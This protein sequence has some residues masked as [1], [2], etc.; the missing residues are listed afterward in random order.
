MIKINGIPLSSSEYHKNPEPDFG[1]NPKFDLNNLPKFKI[2]AFVLTLGFGAMA[3]AYVRSNWWILFG[4]ILNIVAAVAALALKEYIPIPNAETHFKYG[5]YGL[6]IA[7]G[8]L[9]VRRFNAKSSNDSDL[10]S[11]VVKS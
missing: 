3:L 9:D 1:S 11:P 6:I 4:L 8:Q 5:Y 7:I 2:A 10:P